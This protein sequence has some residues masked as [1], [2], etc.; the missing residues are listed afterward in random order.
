MNFIKNLGAS[1]KESFRKNV[2]S[3]KRNPK[4]IP[5]IIL[6]I[7]FVYFSL[8][9]GAISETTLQIQLRK[10]VL[11]AAGL[12]KMDAAGNLVWKSQN[13]GL[14]AFAIMLLSVLSVVCI[15]NAFPRRKKVNIPMLAIGILMIGIVIYC[16]LHYTSCIMYWWENGDRRFDYV[17]KAYK[18]LY[19]HMYITI[20]GL[21]AIVLMPVYTKLLGLIN[22][23]VNLEDNGN[24]D[25]IEL[26]ED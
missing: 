5:M 3:L 10:P 2:V 24:M 26:S 17:S 21:V 25:A 14:T 22:T 12:Q 8:N 16:D 9:L 7:A 13:M 20:A 18:A 19:N 6:L 4:I 1:L 23:K 15:L 11:D